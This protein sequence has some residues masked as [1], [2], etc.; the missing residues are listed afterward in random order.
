MTIRQVDQEAGVLGPYD[1][2]ALWGI[3]GPLFS[4]DLFEGE[5]EALLGWINARIFD[6]AHV[7]Q[8]SWCR[9]GPDEGRAYCA[10]RVL[11][12]INNFGDE[13]VLPTWM[14]AGTVGA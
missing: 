1:I 13:I 12:S 14:L 11:R 3:G 2:Y 6:R 10:I 8:R 9:P 5:R 7:E 4:D